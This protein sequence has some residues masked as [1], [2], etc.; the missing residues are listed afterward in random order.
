MTVSL[1]TL[2]RLGAAIRSIR[3][4]LRRTR[5][6][7]VENLLRAGAYPLAAAGFVLLFEAGVSAVRHSLSPLELDVAGA[8]FARDVA[9]A[10][11]AGA[12][13]I[14]AALGVT[15]VVLDGLRGARTRGIGV[16]CAPLMLA[17]VFFPQPGAFELAAAMTVLLVATR[18]FVEA[19]PIASP[20]PSPERSRTA[21]I[22]WVAAAVFVNLVG[23][24]V[25]RE[26]DIPEAPM[27]VWL[28]FAALVFASLGFRW[29]LALA[30]ETVFAV[31]M[32]IARL[33]LELVLAGREDA[34]G[35]VTAAAFLAAAGAMHV[36]TIRRVEAFRAP[37]AVILGVIAVSL[38]AVE[39]TLA[40]R[41]EKET[42]EFRVVPGVVAG[43]GKYLGKVLPPW[44]LDGMHETWFVEMGRIRGKKPPYK[45]PPGE[46]RIVALG[47]SSTE[48]FE[49]DEDKNV[50]PGRL[51]T[52]LRARD[53]KRKARVLNAGVPGTT[54]FRMMLNLRHELVRYSP[55]IVIL[56]AGHNDAHYS[57]GA[58]T[59]R[60]L[61]ELAQ[62]IGTDP[63]DVRAVEEYVP[64]N[65]GD[66]V[67]APA[68]GTTA[69]DRW[70]AR[71]SRL[72]LYRTMRAA[73]VGA[74]DTA[75]PAV[76]G[77]SP[78]RAR[79]IPPA[80][81]AVI[82]G[83]IL[84]TCREHGARLVIV[85]EATQGRSIEPYGSLMASFAHKYGLPFLDASE[86]MS[87]CAPNREPLFIDH[88]HLTI[89]GHDCLAAA[90]ADLLVDRRLLT[91]V[92]IAVPAAG[93]SL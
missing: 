72:A 63:R 50:W 75:L 36:L 53:R 21:R 71:L 61:F 35:A 29:R 39:I 55:D 91:P 86:V 64:G 17:A 47:S 49:I 42:A 3:R 51:E 87:A 70:R 82:L 7:T 4:R 79:A 23:S 77:L 54:T 5:A 34:P 2:S 57:F 68:P 40:T 12:A 31:L 8:I 6:A 27:F 85:A 38:V 44:F 60:Q 28:A 18:K 66:A 45:K 62:E 33:L 89:A 25:F 46:V 14:L 13:A 15:H 37:N 81:V 24:Q 90:L 80:E 74:R 1:F 30:V 88:V 26:S 93:G 67:A 56:Y 43:Q 59:D 10:R 41:D 73:I 69:F 11:V 20:F 92:K 76:K 48:G 32:I 58:Y 52:I 19:V 65:P 84:A 9:K 22:A 83:E 16:L 78:M